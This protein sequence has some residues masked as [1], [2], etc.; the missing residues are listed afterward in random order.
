M[1]PSS[2]F[3][4]V[5]RTWWAGIHQ[6]GRAGRTARPWAA[7]RPRVCSECTTESSRNTR[8]WPRAG[9]HPPT[10]RSRASVACVPGNCKEQSDNLQMAL[11]LS[12]TL[13]NA[14]ESKLSDKASGQHVPPSFAIGK[15]CLPRAIDTANKTNGL[16]G[17]TWRKGN[18]KREGKKKHM[19][20]KFA[21]KKKRKRIR[22]KTGNVSCCSQAEG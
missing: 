1:L 9:C 18:R 17:N 2:G 6:R 14:V 20:E 10:S 15:Q 4:G 13:L 11:G 21:K 12:A 3:P 22:S 16:L 19:K 8:R 7:S 5:G